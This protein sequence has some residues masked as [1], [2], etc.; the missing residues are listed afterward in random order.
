MPPQSQSRKELERA[1]IDLRAT[2]ARLLQAQKLEAIGQLAAGIAHAL[3]T[4]TQYVTIR[5]PPSRASIGQGIPWSSRRAASSTRPQGALSPEMV[6]AAELAFADTRVD[7]L[8]EEA[9][10][11]LAQSIRACIASATSSPR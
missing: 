1:L 5:A 6:A 8:L 4:P 11:A 7:Y 3:N 2:Q 10:K 9:P